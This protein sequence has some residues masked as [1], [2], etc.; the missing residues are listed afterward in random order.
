MSKKG[1]WLKGGVVGV[2]VG[3]IAGVLFFIERNFGILNT[4]LFTPTRS[5]QYRT[6]PFD[7]NFT[8]MVTSTIGINSMSSA[9]RLS[10]RSK[11]RFISEP[12]L[13]FRAI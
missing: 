5:D 11:K 12:T 9:K 4:A 10:K 8:A 6:G 13:Q 2:V 1:S 3:A 7:V